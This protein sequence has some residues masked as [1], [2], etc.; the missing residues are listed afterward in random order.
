M[1]AEGAMHAVAQRTPRLI[2]LALL[3][4]ERVVDVG[5]GA[6]HLVDVLGAVGL[7]G[8]AG[9]NRAGVLHH[10]DMVLVGGAPRRGDRG[11][12]SALLQIAERLLERRIDRRH[13]LGA[14]GRLN[15]PRR[16]LLNESNQKNSAEKTRTHRPL[17]YSHITLAWP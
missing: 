17:R 13:V 1:S 6:A 9:E 16:C 14:L 8:A 2:L 10:L 12:A 7:G 5:D 3:V 4:F 15:Y 11:A